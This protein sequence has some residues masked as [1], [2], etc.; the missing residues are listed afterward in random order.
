[1]WLA[2]KLTLISVNQLPDAANKSGPIL[3][4]STAL[5]F[6]RAHLSC[7]QSLEARMPCNAAS[8]R[9]KNLLSMLILVSLETK[10][11]IVFRET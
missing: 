3:L 9:P 10:L 11:Y 6:Q 1:M 5:R 8:H 2:G 7:P 4:L